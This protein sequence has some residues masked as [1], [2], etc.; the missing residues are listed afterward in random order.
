MKLKCPSPLCFSSE[1]DEDRRHSLKQHLVGF[2][3]DGGATSSTGGG[4]TKSMSLLKRLG[5]NLLQNLHYGPSTT[6]TS[7]TFNN[8]EEEEPE[9]DRQ[10]YHAYDHQ[11]QP[12]EK[13]PE[14]QRGGGRSRVPIYV[15]TTAAHRTEPYFC[16]KYEI[17]RKHKIKKRD[18][19]RIS[20]GK[21]HVS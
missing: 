13:D 14:Q 19:V 12:P 1:S 7:T 16:K 9:E 5:S 3:D 11:R 17:E 21:P 10:F 8:S 20:R 4:A 15:P 2:R 18:L 6:S